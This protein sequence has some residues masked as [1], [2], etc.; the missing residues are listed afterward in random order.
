[1]LSASVEKIYVV[2]KGNKKVV[3]E[4]CR[5]SNGMLFVVPLITTKHVYKTSDDEEKEWN[6]DTSKAEEIEYMSL[7]RNIREALSRLKII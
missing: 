4:L 2:K 5:A 6:Y 7:P 3:V 1:M